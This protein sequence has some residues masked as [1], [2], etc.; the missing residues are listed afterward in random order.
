MTQVRAASLD[1]MV[2]AVP[3]LDEVV[4]PA[5]PAPA[6]AS[7]EAVNL[8]AEVGPE[9]SAELDVA[10][11]QEILM[12]SNLALLSCP[13]WLLKSL[14]AHHHQISTMRQWRR[15]HLNL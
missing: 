7:A 3:A 14:L 5:A 10:S 9:P 11:V 2:L 15:R 1:E 13:P 12:T 8:A 6:N 4:L